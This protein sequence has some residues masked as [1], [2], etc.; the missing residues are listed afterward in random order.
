MPPG[1]QLRLAADG[2]RQLLQAATVR[3]EVREPSAGVTEIDYLQEGWKLRIVTLALPSAAQ[4]Q[5]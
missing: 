2:T 5:R 1:W 4:E 3:V